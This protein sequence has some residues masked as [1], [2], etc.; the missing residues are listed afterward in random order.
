MPTRS[1][2]F[3]ATLI[4]FTFAD[5][6]LSNAVQVAGAIPL[7]LNNLCGP[8]ARPPALVFGYAQIHLQILGFRMMQCLCC[9]VAKDPQGPKKSPA[10][11]VVGPVRWPF[12]LLTYCATH[13]SMVLPAC[14]VCKVE[15]LLNPDWVWLVIP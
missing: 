5:Q 14:G 13:C 10:C 8:D 4:C 3:A 9:W 15:E 12:L 2:C 11:Q 1:A 6:P 7:Y